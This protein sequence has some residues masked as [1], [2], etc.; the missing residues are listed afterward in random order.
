DP[1]QIVDMRRLVRSLRGEHTVLI[2]SHILGEISETCDRILV[3]RDGRI[4]AAGTE[5][6]LVAQERGERVDVLVRGSDVAERVRQAIL[7][8]DGD[9]QVEVKASVE[10]EVSAFSV[11]SSTDR[12]AE[13]CRGLVGAGLELV[14]L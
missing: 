1:A 10:P 13:L 12:R 2:S 4:V 5:S 11:L 7:L 14:G 8:V 9:A 6:E 3:I